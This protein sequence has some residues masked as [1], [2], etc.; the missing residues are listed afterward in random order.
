METSHE[1]RF[2]LFVL[3]RFEPG[4][5]RFISR[6]GF[7]AARCRASML[8]GLSAGIEPLVKRLQTAIDADLPPVDSYRIAELAVEFFV[9]R[10][11]RVEVYFFAYPTSTHYPEPLFCLNGLGP[12]PESNGSALHFPIKEETS[13]IIPD[14]DS[15]YG[16]CRFC[17]DTFAHGFEHASL[18]AEFQRGFSEINWAFRRLAQSTPPILRLENDD[19]PWSTVLYPHDEP[20]DDK[21]SI[22]LSDLKLDD[23]DLPLPTFEDD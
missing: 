18:P 21:P 10:N 4:S 19:S 13:G 5:Q 16:H 23:E 2:T 9:K 3:L 11:G 7:E 22:I 8:A 12:K 6:D 1:R 17:A 14:P 15:L 20:I